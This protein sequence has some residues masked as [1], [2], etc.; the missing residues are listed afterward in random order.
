MNL[1]W[2]VICWPL[3]CVLAQPP[4]APLLADQHAALMSV[5]DGLGSSLVERT[6]VCRCADAVI[7]FVFFF[8]WAGCNDTAVC[9]RFN[10][11]SNCPG[12]GLNLRLNCTGGKV[13][14][15]YVLGS[16]SQASVVASDVIFMCSPPR[17]LPFQALTGSIPSTIGQLSALTYLYAV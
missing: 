6:Y 5:Y 16:C 9:P 7:I 1:L 17:D 12:L 10:A 8:I 3:L 14:M 4:P 2:L 13:T 15:L 11:S